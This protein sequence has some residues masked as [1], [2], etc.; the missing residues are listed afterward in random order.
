MNVRAKSMALRLALA[1]LMTV[2]SAW[3]Q[4]YREQEVSIANGP[5]IL[6]GTLTLPNSAGPFTA[7]ILISGS[8]PQDRDEAIPQIPGYKPFAWIADH[9]TKAGYAV[10][11]YDDRGTGKSSGNFAASTSADFATDAEAV[12]GYI[13]SRPEINPQKVGLFGHSEGGLIAAMIS[14]RNPKVAFVISM[15]GPGVR[16]Y[17]LLLVQLERVLKASNTPQ[18]Q[19]VKMMADQR[20]SLDLILTKDWKGLEERMYPVVLEQL[21]A[22]PEDKRKALGDLEA[23][24]RVQTQQGVEATK[25]WLAFFVAYDPGQD[26]A[27]VKV[28]VLAL[29]GGLDVQVDVR[30]NRIALET[31][32]ARAGNKNLTVRVFEE[33]NH[34]FQ[35]AKTGSPEEYVSLPMQFVS[36]FL[37]SITDW[38][39]QHFPAKQGAGP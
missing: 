38:L 39:N 34:L 29:F 5:I 24:A 35:A 13:T 9:L 10:L 4:A 7:L 14:A 18:D 37:Q 17:E 11:R 33:A 3:A 36:G 25:G 19:I 30:Q 1:A 2:G 26:W 21:R 12:L 15:A 27:G 31:A 20:K 32:L 16:G 6:S 8:G 28:P 23:A 22:L